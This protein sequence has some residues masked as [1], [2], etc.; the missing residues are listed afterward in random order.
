MPDQKNN[1]NKKT[2]LKDENNTYSTKIDNDAYLTNAT[3]KEEGQSAAAGEIRKYRIKKVEH[4]EAPTEKPA[5]PPAFAE[6]EKKRSAIDEDLLR[7]SKQRKK[8]KIL[9]LDL[10]AAERFFPDFSQGL[11][12]EQVNY[13]IEKGYTNYTTKKKGKTYPAI[14]LSNIFTFFNILTFIVGAA[15]MLSRNADFGNYFFLFIISANIVIGIVQEVRSKRTIDKLSIVSAPSATVVRGGEKRAI[16]IAAIVL[17]D[18]VFTEMGKQI[19]ADCIVVSGAC[20][21]N[22]SMLTGESEPVKKHAGDTLYSGSYVSS[23]SCYAR[24]DKVGDAN[25]IETLAS[26]AKKY[27]KPKSELQ[28]SIRLIM[29]I[30]TCFIIPI[31][32]FM[33]FFDLKDIP[34][35]KIWDKLVGKDDIP[36]SVVKW[37]GAIIGMIP[38]GMFLLTSM[39]LAVGVIRLAKKHTL[40][41]DLYCIE[42]LARADVLCLD[43]T[44]TLTD[45][46][47]QVH[48]TVALF[49][50]EDA[51]EKISRIIGSILT[52]TEDNNQTA[53]ALAAKFGYNNKLKPKT[54]L[55]FSSQRK[56]SAVTFEEEGTFIL[57]APEF[58]LKEMGIRLD[59]LVAEYAGQGYRVICLASVAGEITAD[60]RLPT[61]R[62]PWALIVIEDHIREDASKTIKWFREND[63]AVKIISGDNPV[64][65]SEVARRVG[66]E[67]AELYIS[68]DGLSSQEVIEAANKYTVFG[69]VTPEQ[70]SLLIK[71]IKAKGHTVAMTGDGVNDILAM[72]EADCSIA[73]ASGAEAARNVS[74]LVLLDSNFSS[75]PSV[76]VEGRRVV[77]N[78]TKASS[79]F[80]TKTFMSIVLSIVVL[81]LSGAYFFSTKNL[82]LLEL[83]VIGVPSFALALQTN[84]NR[85]RG[86]FLANVV[87]R[88]IPGGMALVIS[89]LGVYFYRDGIQ[90]Q[91]V[92]SIT[93]TDPIFETLL[94]LALSFTGMI[95]LAKICEPFNVLRVFVFL[96][97][98]AM[99]TICI[100][101]LGDMGEKLF[102][103]V[104]LAMSE[105]NAAFMHILFVFGVVL[106]SYF[107]I[108][109]IMKVLK[110]LNVMYD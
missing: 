102:G 35:D 41:Q 52:A 87:S 95:V 58:I 99:M 7:A 45:G 82:L 97:S 24:V 96:G 20:E 105:S 63:V 57:G 103:V 72:R 30:V 21:V 59:R 19:S 44:G 89:V 36:G 29:K 6:T 76:V 62:K 66:V 69:R 5:E 48:K 84:T 55:P 75:M 56:F 53:L 28:N 43:K 31:A 70:K 91:A 60:G 3:P 106:L 90:A 93:I 110:A 64:T 40:V 73:I 12:D 37:A 65:V 80:L 33:I 49:K 38:A 108:T 34:L 61:G 32:F 11:T 2:L 98:M 14:I 25:Y 88:A 26:H 22:E 47:M 23:G 81:F 15:L 68:L 71:S 39:A 17:D 9:N 92:W 104:P 78:I 16:P 50:D 54:V 77:N 42:M 8:P 13:R 74:H 67:N 109:L 101:L 107:I 10:V 18:I 46:S 85:I 86:N 83:F 51:G 27:K 94:V 100:F 1:K 79:L 4:K